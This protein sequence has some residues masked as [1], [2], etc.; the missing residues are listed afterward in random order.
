VF[1]TGYIHTYVFTRN[2]WRVLRESSQAVQV[3]CI[4]FSKGLLLGAFC[5]EASLHLLYKDNS[6]SFLSSHGN[7]RK[8]VANNNSNFI[9]NSIL[10]WNLSNGW[11]F[12]SAERMAGFSFHTVCCVCTLSCL[13]VVSKAV[14]IALCLLVF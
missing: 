8:P 14:L 1:L 13:L 7:C 12:L 4:L 6:F 3:N 5:R 10:A 9:S 11:N 2:S